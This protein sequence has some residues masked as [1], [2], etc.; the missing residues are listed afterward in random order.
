MAG[1]V[2]NVIFWGILNI[3]RSNPQD[4]WG[5][6]QRNGVNFHPPASWDLPT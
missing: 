2:A 6:K 3:L 5:L 1:K 4:I